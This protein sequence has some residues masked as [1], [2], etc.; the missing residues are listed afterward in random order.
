MWAT[1]RKKLGDYMKKCLLLALIAISL[2]A[3]VVAQGKEDYIPVGP[4]DLSVTVKDSKDLPVFTNVTQITRPWGNIGVQRVKNL[5]N[6]QKIIQSYIDKFKN[7]AAEH[8]GDAIII[9]QY[10]DEDAANKRPINLATN[11]VKYLDNLPEEDKQ[12]IVTFAQTAA[13]QAEN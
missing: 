10:F 12:K 13:M 6:D 1:C 4:Q 8:G 11:I 3:C 2:T 5:P 7:F 9:K